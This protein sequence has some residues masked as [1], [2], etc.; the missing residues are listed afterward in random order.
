MKLFPAQSNVR[1]Y[2]EG[3]GQDDPLGRR[4]VGQKLSG[5]LERVDD[6]VV[7]ALDGPWGS[8]KSHFLKRWVGAHKIENGGLATTVYFDA[9]AHDFL[10]DPLI[11]LTSVIGS[12]IEGAAQRTIFKSVKKIAAKLARPAIRIGAA[13]ATAGITEVVGPVADALVEGVGKEA[14]DRVNEFWRREDG[15]IAAM[16]QFR[17]ALTSLT[18]PSQPDADDGV[19]LI[20]VIDELDRCRP[21][22]ALSML[23][24]IKHFFAVPNVHFILGVNL[25]AL[26][27]SV[28]ARYGARVDAAEYLKRFIALSVRLPEH[29]AEDR[30]VQSAVSYFGIC[31]NSMG[32]APRLIELVAT[33]IKLLSESTNRPS[34][35]DI[36]RILTRLVL[37]PKL[38]DLPNY[39]HG[40]QLIVPSLVIMQVMD[41]SLYDAA[42]RGNL[43]LDSFDKL[44]GIRSE[45][46]DRRPGP[47]RTFNHA[48][49]ILRGCW[50][51][52][53]SNG[54]EPAAELDNFASA[55]DSFGRS[56][57]SSIM[58]NIDRDFFSSFAI[59]D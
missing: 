57:A 45:M 26:E 20:V 9:F 36:E 22:Y 47:D 4:G 37:L 13:V 56:D 48:A 14:E 53:L 24:V 41:A 23:E 39:H 3:F 10:D 12:R 58:L 5:L 42:L 29:V 32:L 30:R 35:R 54:V 34:L 49:A 52:V 1:I 2:E 44:F 19:S 28:S 43:T 8:G 18:A 33:Q 55:F 21:D 6:P 51:Y 15:R 17:S 40:Y 7:I 11:G 16:E 59:N 25:T 38:N 46:L 50:Q 31:A 27:N